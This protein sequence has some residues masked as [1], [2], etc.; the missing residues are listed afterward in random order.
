MILK[1]KNKQRSNNNKKINN[2]KILRIQYQKNLNS[3]HTQ[4]SK[5]HNLKEIM[6][7]N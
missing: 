2:K 7:N 4:I 6:I 1:N 5:N 3:M